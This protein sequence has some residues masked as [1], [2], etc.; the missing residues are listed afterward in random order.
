MSAALR[1]RQARATLW[2]GLDDVPPDLGPTVLTIGVFDGL[3]RGHRSLIDKAR[4]TADERGLPLVMVTF[5]PHP[6]RVLGLPKDTATLSTIAHRAEL[7]AAA[8]VDAVCVLRFTRE[9]AGL[10]PE[11]FAAHCLAGRL[12]AKAVV[13]GANFTFGARAAGDVDTLR[14]LGAALGFSVEGVPLLPANNTA[15]SSTYTR[16]CLRSGD[17]PGV[18]RALGR[19]HRVDGV[20]AGDRIVLAP[21]TALPPP[22]RYRAT[23][24]G[25]AVLVDVRDDSVRVADGTSGEGAAAVT[26]LERAGGGS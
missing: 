4:R 3:H 23:L 8:G 22:G 24:N 7:A 18:T 12:R 13:V 5:D 17:L 19:P 15:C 11:T 25:R 21:N 14:E 2:H 10:S 20:R 1:S 16:N 6:A 26:F 9:L